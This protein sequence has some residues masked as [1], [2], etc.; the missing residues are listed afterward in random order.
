MKNKICEISLFSLILACV[1]SL[2]V[3][4]RVI[5]T[6]NSNRSYANAYQQVNAMRYQQEYAA[7]EAAT[8]EL[9][10]M[11]SDEQLKAAIL[12]GTA[13]NVTV[14]DLEACSMIYP[15]G[16]FKWEIPESGVRRNQTPQCVAVVE[17]RDVNNQNAVL[18]T[19]TVAAGDT[20]K[21]NIDSFP[22]SGLSFNVKYGKVELPADAAPTMDDVI[23]VMNEEQKQNAGLKIAAGAII[24]GLAGNILAPKQAD[25]QKMFGTGKT[26]LIDTAIGTAAGAGIMAAGSY[27]GKV[28]GDTIKSTA[29]NAA[30]GMVLG[31]MLAGASGGDTVIATTKC[32]VD[33]EEKDCVIGTCAIKKTDGVKIE[34]G[35]G[36]NDKYYFIKKRS[37]NEM[38]ECE[39]VNGT[40][41]SCV[42]VPVSKYTDIQVDGKLC[43]SLSESEYNNVNES[44][45]RNQDNPQKLELAQIVSNGEFLIVSHAEETDGREHAY[46]ILQDGEMLKHPLGIKL[47]DFKDIS[48]TAYYYRNNDYTVDIKKVLTNCDFDPK[49]QDAE[50]GALV[51]INNQS[52]AKATLAGTAAGGAMGGFAGYQG[53]QDEVSQRWVSAVREYQDS[54]SNFVCSTGG[55]FLSQYNDYLQIQEL[56]K[57][58]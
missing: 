31:N 52:R 47:A 12:D 28:A 11:V 22:E 1:S 14:S 54:L 38:L 6:N 55:R 58:E 29:V 57:S 46:A 16:V 36:N 21:C 24:G 19:T 27:S 51:D 48:V 43:S 20:F 50:D 53:A 10:V 33:K 8:A 2:P 18:A 26:Q 39:Q 34:S 35:V 44:F 41:T 45:I 23:A 5:T 4:A 42:Q 17:L 7:T 9:P 13:E 30:S 25:N 32:K 49:T 3:D 56:K 15:N 40:Y 37:C